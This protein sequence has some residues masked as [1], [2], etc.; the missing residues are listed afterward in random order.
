VKVI[1]NRHPL[2]G[3]SLAVLG[4]QHRRGALH[5]VLVLPD[6]TRS[7]IPASWTDLSH[8]ENEP[9]APKNQATASVASV[10]QLLH[11]RTVVDALLRRLQASAS[12]DPYPEEITRAAVHIFRRASVTREPASGVA[13]SRSPSEGGARRRAL[14]V[15]REG[16]GGATEPH[17]GSRGA[18]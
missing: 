5:V 6:G 2:E 11:M 10:V 15:D 16:D 4:W 3:C 13:E 12:D 18:R 14:T 17:R 9:P 7:L 8:D 1:R